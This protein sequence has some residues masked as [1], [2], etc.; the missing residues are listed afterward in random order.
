MSDHRKLSTIL[1]ADIVGYTALMQ[2][3]ESKAMKYL[4]AFKAELQKKVP[5]FDGEIVQYYGDACLLSF[6]STSEGVKCAIEIQKYFQRIEI[7][8]RIG[9][10]LGEVIFTDDNVFGDGVNIASRIE[11]MGVP[12]AVLVSKTVRDQIKNKAEFQLKSLGNFDYKNVEE[13]VEV[14]ALTNAGLNIPLAHELKGKFKTPQEDTKSTFISTLW[15]KK[16]LQHLTL[17][18][19][20]AYVVFKVLEWAFLKIGL[21]PQWALLILIAFIGVIPSLLIYLNNRDRIHQSKLN[22]GEKILFPS[23]LAIV[24][25]VVFFMFKSTEVEAISKDITYI[26]LDGEEETHNIIK[27]KFK[28]QFPVFPFEPLNQSDTRE[29]WIGKGAPITISYLLNQD[30]YLKAYKHLLYGKR[31]IEGGHYTTVEKIELSRKYR[32]DFYIDG[33]YQYSDGQHVMIPAVK[34]KV[35]GKTIQEK[36]F[37]STDLFTLTDSVVHF[38]RQAVGLSPT[39]IDESL[40]LRLEEVIQ[41]KNAEAIEAYTK[42]LCLGDRIQTIQSAELDTTWTIP[43]LYIIDYI[44]FYSEGELEAKTLIAQVMRHMNHLPFD[45]QIGIRVRKHMIYEEWDKAEQLL[46]L[47]I[48]IEPD[49]DDYKSILSRLY[50]RQFD[51]DKYVEHTMNH[52]KESPRVETAIHAARAGLQGGMYDEV[53]RILQQF[54]ERDPK[55]IWALDFLAEAYIHQ[56]K[57]ELAEETINKII[58]FNPNLELS[59]SKSLEAIR[60]LKS[61]SHSQVDLLIFTGDFRTDYGEMRI[62]KRI[63]QNHIY[64]QSQNQNGEFYYLAGQHTVHRSSPG[65]S[66][67][68]DLIFD[69]QNNVVAHNRTEISGFRD[70]AIIDWKQDSMIWKAENLLVNGQYDEAYRAYQTAIEV[71]PSHYYL[72]KHFEHLEYLKDHTSEEAQRNLKLKTGEYNGARIWVENGLLNCRLPGFS[73]RILRPISHEQFI[74]L[75]EYNIIYEF[76]SEDNEVVGL[77]LLTHDFDTDEWNMMP[78]WHYNQVEFLNK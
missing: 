26:N 21:S 2:S 62:K 70:L 31:A 72:K 44:T 51:M 15:D 24:A 17:Y 55:L 77:R 7:P 65:R 25:L 52:Y 35:N 40:V 30:K 16:I 20:L 37:A 48:E 54:L 33:K 4:D 60:Y 34:N 76:V 18:I 6:D 69:D 53:I 9:M 59:L 39:Q 29:N 68:I 74:S 73:R 11:S 42:A 45:E 36:S 66:Y 46:K 57:Y 3:D 12:G 47:Q 22:L 50:L 64:S 49:N 71:Y 27:S 38:L 43:A 28:K 41:S 63:I 61:A 78:H 67:T 1:F 5:G 75:S 32:G 10:H 19:L 13:P 23:N 56:E 58:L 14:Y 8:I